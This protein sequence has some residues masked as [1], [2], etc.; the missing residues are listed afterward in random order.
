MALGTA[1]LTLPAQ[2][3][4]AVPTSV[5]TP[6]SQIGSQGAGT[7]GQAPPVPALPM[8]DSVLWQANDQQDGFY[9][10]LVRPRSPG[11]VQEVWDESRPAAPVYA[12]DLCRDCTYKVRLRE[13]MVTVIE[14][15]RGEVID[16]VDIGDAQ[17]FQV[18]KRGTRR[19]A[20]R[21]VG[22][23]Y[24]SN[25]IVYGKSGVV[26][27]IYLRTEGFNSENTPDLVV[28]IN[29]AVAMP[30]ERRLALVAFGDD[31]TMRTPA[32][33]P[34][35]AGVSAM[36]DAVRG[37]AETDPPIPD[38]DFVAD[39]VF[40]PATLRGWGD[41][42]LWGS[43]DSLKPETVFRDDHFTYLRFGDTWKDIELPT[44]YVVVD[45]IDE[46]VNTRVQGQTYI[47]ES[48]RPL[49]TLKSGKSYLCIRYTGETS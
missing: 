42:E 6:G 18:S 31:G 2:A 11:Q 22:A 16:A 21:P 17:G 13:W 7:M 35:A 37:L 9:G 25:L 48:T 23:G 39:A 26:Y 32:A 49:I 27:P 46:L 3:Q 30:G 5:P 29:G 47:I 19:L 36:A 34:P 45:D 10:H 41:Y 24:D 14:L 44:A 28:R 8:P 15:P 38:G 12:T 43:D 20:L 4:T 33:R 40:D 1:G